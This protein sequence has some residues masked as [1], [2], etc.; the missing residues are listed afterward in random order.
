MS[1]AA[2]GLAIDNSLPYALL[3][4]HKFSV[5]PQPQIFNRY[6]ATAELISFTTRDGA[7]I[8]GWFIPTPSPKQSQTLIILHSLGG[9]RQDF[10]E[11]ALPLWN[12]GY[13][14]A[15]I[16]LRGHGSSS[17]E[18]FTYGYHEWQDVS[19]L[20]DYLEQRNVKKIS[21]MGISAG[22][23]VAIASA[24]H[25]PRIQSLITIGT[26]AD[27]NHTIDQQVSFLP[28]I[29]RDR[30]KARAED[31]GHFSINDVSAI[32][33]IQ[34]VNCPIFIA[35]GTAD[36]YIPFEDGQTLYRNAANPKTFYAIP[37]ATHAT[38]LTQEPEKLQT[39][40][41]RF[42]NHTR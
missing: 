14:L 25:D 17:G 38:M 11:F 8:N 7:K 3:S 27:L 19:G 34:K 1:I 22:G 5:E 12:Q 39:Q 18:F 16:D 4:H 35:H 40:I 29:W 2:I 15:L 28:A 26:F 41:L 9:T 30:A 13:N 23:T 42:L 24:V 33:N 37:N 21:V 36:T 6:N 20:I 31:L 10:L 32:A